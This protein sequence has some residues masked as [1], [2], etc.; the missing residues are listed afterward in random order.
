MRGRGYR[1][2]RRL[3]WGRAL[4]LRCSPRRW[5]FHAIRMLLLWG[6]LRRPV[7]CHRN[8]CRPSLSS[9]TLYHITH[10]ASDSSCSQSVLYYAGANSHQ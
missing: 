10:N 8:C 3:L 1:G 5:L 7:R 6:L 9:S 2:V 4:P